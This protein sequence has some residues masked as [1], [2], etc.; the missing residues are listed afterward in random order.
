MFSNLTWMALLFA[1]ILTP[2]VFVRL[3]NDRSISISEMILSMVIMGAATIACFYIGKNL[4]I[5]DNQIIS[6]EIIDKTREHG[7]YIQTYDCN[8]VDGKCQTCSRTIYT[9]HWYAVANIA[10]IEIDSTSSEFSSVYNKDDPERYKNIIIGEPAST[11]WTFRNYIA[12]TPDSVFHNRTVDPTYAKMMPN[13]PGKIYDFYRINRVITL[14]NVPINASD[15]NQTLAQYMK[16]WGPQNKGNVI[17]VFTDINNRGFTESLKNHW[18]QGKQND[19]VIVIGLEQNKILWTNVFSWTENETFKLELA[20]SLHDL[21]ILNK[22]SVFSTIDSHM[23]DFKYRD[24]G[25]DF[26]YL[27]HMIEPHIIWVPLAY[28]ISILLAIGSI[29]LKRKYFH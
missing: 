15:W 17:L 21:E 11:T 18:L 12:A 1:V 14:G 28:L 20:D 3:R 19:V 4:K 29:A 16:K 5:S 25:T 23:K 8:C 2:P 26:E 22:D 10:K 6:G 7:S 27:D 24:M 13:Y 9:V